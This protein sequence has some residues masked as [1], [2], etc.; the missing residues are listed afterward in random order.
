IEPAGPRFPAADAHPPRRP[1]GFPGPVW[2]EERWTRVP[3]VRYLRTMISGVPVVAAHAGIDII[4]AALSEGGELRLGL[5][6]DCAASHL[7]ER[8]LTYLRTQI[9][10][11]AETT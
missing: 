5:P 6:A 7:L 4:T 9:T 3:D 1:T 8:A 11:P 2:P 10:K